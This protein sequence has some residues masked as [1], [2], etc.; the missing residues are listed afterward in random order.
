MSLSTVN[1]M[2]TQFSHPTREPAPISLY[3]FMLSDKVD[4]DEDPQ[5]DVE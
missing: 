3:D 5:I 2:N 4:D 1:W